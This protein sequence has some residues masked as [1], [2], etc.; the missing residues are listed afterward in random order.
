MAGKTSVGYG[1]AA[2]VL[3][4]VCGSVAAAQWLTQPARVT[5]GFIEGDSPETAIVKAFEARQSRDRKP[6][7]VM[8]LRGFADLAALR[9]AF[10]RGAV[11]IAPFAT[12]EAVPD[13]AETV[14]ILQRTRVVL[15]ALDRDAARRASA[16]KVVVVSAD[17]ASYR[18]GAL[19]VAAAF[20]GVA[21]P[22]HLPAA[23]AA[24]A[25]KSGRAEIAAVAAPNGARLLREIIAALP[26]ADQ[27]DVTVRAAPRA[28]QLS[29]QYPAIE[30]V[31]LKIGS[32]SSDPL[33]PDDDIET[34][35]VTTR[36]MARRALSESV[37]TDVTR[38]L[39]SMQ[40]RLAQTTPAAIGI[41]PPPSDRGA[42]FPTHVGAAAYVDGE[43]RTFFERYGDWLYLVLFGGS[44]VGSIWAGLVGWRDA[45]R[46]RADLRRLSALQTLVLEVADAETRQDVAEVTAR[47]R[48]L[49]NDVVRASAR[50]E[51]SQTDLIAF[52]MASGLFC[53][54][55][56]ERVQA[57][58]SSADAA[59]PGL[60]HG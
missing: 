30:S 44:G 17:D 39:L 46:R 4:A 54:T 9:E 53:E 31:E 29:R 36:L 19:I 49:M 7:F 45:K 13:S 8:T 14:A 51:V 5:V 40:R 23:E 57:M 41:E 52:T 18:L 60:E 32:V 21:A 1:L 12:W 3:A 42:A 43:E 25:L 55:R 33:L 10:G 6:A 26:A 50:L 2:A 58:A 34:L 56:Q 28:D 11:D 37:V 35:S 20:N 27:A 48:A 59:T 38:V 22:P 47:Y 15:V 24:R 16:E